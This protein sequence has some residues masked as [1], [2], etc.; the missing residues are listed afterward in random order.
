MK[1]ETHKENVVMGISG[2]VDSIQDI[3]SVLDKSIIKKSN[4]IARA[5]WAVTS[6]WHQRI[7]VAVLSQILPSDEDFHVYTVRLRDLACA[8]GRDLDG[9]FY[10]EI[11]AAI[12]KI[13]SS[14]LIIRQEHDITLTVNAFSS[15]ILDR[16]KGEI[17][18][19]FDEELKPHYL[20]LHQKFTTYPML[21]YMGLHSIYSQK[22]YEIL[23]SWRSQDSVII[24]LAQLFEELSTPPSFAKNFKDFRRNV[25]EVCEKDINVNT[26]L[27][28]RWEPIKQSRK[29]VSVKFIFNETTGQ[30]KK[31][32]QKQELEEHAKWQRLSNACYERHQVKKMSCKPGKGKKCKY[33]LERG[34]M[35]GKRNAEQQIFDLS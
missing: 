3:F 26:Q 28:Y 17:R 32:Q 1:T 12:N 35:F 15:C 8:S 14:P 33:C 24:T 31:Q 10:D 6:L 25:L 34:R 22:L 11:Q 4:A 19:K 21:E 20:R 18:A 7:L 13:F 16:K 23:M 30:M 27:V 2:K 5:S 9:V 29:V